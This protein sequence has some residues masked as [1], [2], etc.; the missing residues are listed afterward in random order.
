MDPEKVEEILQKGRGC[1]TYKQ[2]FHK[3]T[4]EEGLNDVLTKI[5]P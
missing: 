3:L 1:E 4:N 5:I 2:I